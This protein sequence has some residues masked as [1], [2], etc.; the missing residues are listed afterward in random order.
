MVKIIEAPEA[1]EPKETGFRIFLAGT[2]DNG[3]SENWQEKICKHFESEEIDKDVIIYNPRR[4]K[5]DPKKEEL[6]NQIN[7]ELKA[8]EN[9]NIIIMNILGTSKSPISLMELGL[10]HENPGLYVFCPEE[11]Y[12][13]TNVKV[14]CEKY[15]IKLYKNN[16]IEDIER[17]ISFLI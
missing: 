13:F 16:N 11:F 6:E 8:L 10:F 3:E 5:W 17:V 4:S 12:R 14:V 9:S 7:W 2:I 15:G 1:F